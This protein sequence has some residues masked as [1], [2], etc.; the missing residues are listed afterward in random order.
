MLARK[1]PTA[2]DAVIARQILLNGLASDVGVIE[3]LAQLAPLHPRNDTFPG[4]IF[5]R[6]GVDALDWAGADRAHPVPLERF[7]ER[8][9]SEVD[10]RGRDHRKFQFAVLA[11]AAGHGGAEV[12]LL[13]EV[14]WWQSDDFWRYAAYAAIAYIRAVA[15]RAS[16]SVPE[17]CR[18]LAQE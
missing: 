13:D 6:L 7:R 1:R 12:D 5:L 18:A 2:H 4:E 8:F 14:A 3:I 15:D 11:A 9:L 17:V 10:L 16:V